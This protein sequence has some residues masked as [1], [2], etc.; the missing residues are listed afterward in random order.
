MSTIT[1]APPPSPED[2]EAAEAERENFDHIDGLC[3]DWA[4]W[5]RSRRL[6]GP[7]PMTAGTLGK[8]T[9][10]GRGRPSTGPNARN[11]AELSALHLAIIGQPEDKL[12]LVFELHYLHQAANT[13]ATAQAIGISRATWYRHLKD[14]RARVYATSQRI[15]AANLAAADALPHI[16]AS[17]AEA[18]ATESEP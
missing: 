1:T 7:P 6:Y 16:T 13:K 2:L 12:R 15:L 11:S 18:L 10:K 4:A 17:R 5:T 3:W 9:T 14:F 8:L